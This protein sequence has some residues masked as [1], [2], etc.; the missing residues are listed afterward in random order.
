MTPFPIPL[1]NFSLKSWTMKSWTYEMTPPQ[2]RIY[3]TMIVDDSA[4]TRRAS[5]GLTR[6]YT[7]TTEVGSEIAEN[8]RIASRTD[9]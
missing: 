7:A 3:L 8:L 6:S 2:T 1:V 9:G 4:C 5:D